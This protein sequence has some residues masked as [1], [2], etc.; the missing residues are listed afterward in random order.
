MNFVDLK[1]KE[2]ISEI[3][4][5]HPSDVVKIF[6]KLLGFV[7]LT[8]LEGT[9]NFFIVKDLCNKALSVADSEKGIPTTA[10]VCVYPIFVNA[11]ASILKGTDVHVAA[12]AGAFP[13]GQSPL[14]LRLAEVKYA[15]DNGADEIDMVISRGRFLLGDYEFVS[16]EIAKHKEVCKDV[17]L[18]VI[19]ETGELKN[20]NLIYRASMLAMESGADFIKTSTGKTSPAA[21]PEAAFVML[22]AIRDYYTKTGRKVGFKVAGGVREPSVAVHYFQLV[23]AILGSQWLNKNLFRIGASGLLGKLVDA[24]E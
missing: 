22:H 1:V 5:H 14:E 18:K 2:S 19:L 20:L 4:S 3:N 13:S 24:I 23:D 16:D 15:I 6:K 7:D 21:T 17:H 9:D 11:A 12:V 8:T 10:A